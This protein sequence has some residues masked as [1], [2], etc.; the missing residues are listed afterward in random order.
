MV[1]NQNQKP[2]RG[3]SRLKIKQ[4]QNIP[5]RSRQAQGLKAIKHFALTISPRYALF[6]VMCLVILFY[7]ISYFHPE[8]LAN[9]IW[10]NSFLPIILASCSLGF[11]LLKMTKASSRLA[12]S[13][14]LELNLLL[15]LLLQDLTINWWWLLPLLIIPSCYLLFEQI[16]QRLYNKSS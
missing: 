11:A 5:H 1:T 16:R 12:F 14:S 13:V 8:Q 4:Q 6:A 15:W 3:R 2:A 7:L 9:F 10:P